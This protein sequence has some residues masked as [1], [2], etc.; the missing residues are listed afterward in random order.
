MPWFPLI[1]L[2]CAKCWC[3]RDQRLTFLREMLHHLCWMQDLRRGIFPKAW[4]WLHMEQNTVPHKGCRS[5][6]EGKIWP[7]WRHWLL[8]QGLT[9]FSLLWVGL[10]PSEFC[11]LTFPSLCHRPHLWQPG[12]LWVV[13]LQGLLDCPW[14]SR[15]CYI[16]LPP[17][18]P[19]KSLFPIGTSSLR[20]ERGSHVT[21]GTD[22][23]FKK[24]T[25]Q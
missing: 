6:A 19:G 1:I 11:L 23:V 24:K 4:G 22:G 20:E 18:C 13:T 7:I 16:P 15:P 5:G 2:I 9:C 17:L 8:A 12:C 14:N 25:G 3:P 21:R 10:Q